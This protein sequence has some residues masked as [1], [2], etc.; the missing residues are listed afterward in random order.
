MNITHFKSKQTYFYTIRSN[1]HKRSNLTVQIIDEINDLF[2]GFKGVEIL[3]SAL[4]T[5]IRIKIWKKKSLDY[6]QKCIIPHLM[7]KYA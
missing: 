1:F 5:T 7:A 4:S 3:G 6:F 2:L